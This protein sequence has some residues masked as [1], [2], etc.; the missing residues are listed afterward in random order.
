MARTQL[1]PRERNRWNYQDS[2]MTG[3]PKGKKDLPTGRGRADLTSLGVSS[4]PWWK[5]TVMML[6]KPVVHLL[7]LSYRASSVPSGRFIC[8]SVG[9]QQIKD[10][11]VVS[12]HPLVDMPVT[13]TDTPTSHPSVFLQPHC[14]RS[15]ELPKS[16]KAKTCTKFMLS[17]YQNCLL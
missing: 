11:T 8:N 14:Q 9:C 2:G 7:Q 5:K 15:P 1:C 16:R 6:T 13:T 17:A 4:F 12:I 10:W 3:L